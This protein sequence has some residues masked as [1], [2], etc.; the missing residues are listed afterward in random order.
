MLLYL[1]GLA[2]LILMIFMLQLR[3]TQDFSHPRYNIP[4]PVI[5]FVDS[6]H[7]KKSPKNT[8]THQVCVN[9]FGHPSGPLILIKGQVIPKHPRNQ[10]PKRNNMVFRR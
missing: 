8:S 9:H 2:L 10:T 1:A 7:V 3:G 4:D 5:E 6:S